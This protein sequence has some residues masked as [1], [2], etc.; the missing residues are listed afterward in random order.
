MSMGRLRIAGLAVCC[1]S[2]LAGCQTEK[3]SNIWPQSAAPQATA[4]DPGADPVLAET[5]G[6]ITATQPLKPDAGLLG[7]DPNDD[8]N[9]GKKF[10]RSAA[11][12]LA[13]RSFRRAVE[14]HPRDAEAWL[15]L[16]ASYDRLKRFDLADRAY[17]QALALIGPTPELLNNQGYSYMLRGQYTRAKTTLLQAKAK[18]PNNPYV[19]SNLKLL[20]Q[21]IRTGRNV[22]A[23]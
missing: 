23:L 8:L 2:W 19:R 20:D 18:D 22:E 5:T 9:N 21:A 16:A 4:T 15:G 11:Y 10:Y 14:L 12:G 7:A 1:L 17:A 13:E 3:F 6:S